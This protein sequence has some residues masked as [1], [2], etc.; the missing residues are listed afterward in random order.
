MKFG[1]PWVAELLNEVYTKSPALVADPVAKEQ[2]RRWLFEQV[3]EDRLEPTLRQTLYNLAMLRG[4][5]FYSEDELLTEGDATIY[6]L[7]RTSFIEFDPDSRRYHVAPVLS[8]L[9]KEPAL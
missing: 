8:S 6:R 7:I 9:F 4:E 3:V 5:G 1:N 2:V